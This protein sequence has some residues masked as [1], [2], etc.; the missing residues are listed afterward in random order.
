M[1]LSVIFVAAEALGYSRLLGYVPRGI[2]RLAD[3]S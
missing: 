2:H 1:W 3:R